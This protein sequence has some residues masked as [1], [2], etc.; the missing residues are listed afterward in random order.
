M[1]EQEFWNLIYKKSESEFNKGLI[2]STYPS[3]IAEPMCN[4]I[5]SKDKV[6]LL[7]RLH[8]EWLEYQKR[9]SDIIQ[10]Y[11]KHIGY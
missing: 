3:H 5:D 10:A 1:T 2:R 9:Q 11:L 6:E 4:A 7:D 8:K